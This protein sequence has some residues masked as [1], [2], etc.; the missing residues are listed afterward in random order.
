MQGRCSPPSVTNSEPCNSVIGIR[1]AKR[2]IKESFLIT[3]LHYAAAMSLH[4]AYLVSHNEKKMSSV[5]AGLVYA[6]FPNL[7]KIGLWG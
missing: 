2:V 3:R 4:R 7:H 5:Q 1:D 6:G